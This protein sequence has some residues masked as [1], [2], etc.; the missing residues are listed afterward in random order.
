MIRHIVAWNFKEG[1]SEEENLANARKI[2]LAVEALG[3]TIPGVISIEVE[4]SLL[5]SSTH[6]LMLNGLYENEK[7][8]ADYQVHPD[9]LR[10]SEFIKQ[11]TTDRVCLDF[12]EG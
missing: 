12:F 2:K 11:V 10:V 3:S 9:H 1:S 7:S 8:L 6:G 4:I 5:R